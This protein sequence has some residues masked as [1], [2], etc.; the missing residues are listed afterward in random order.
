MVLI[1]PLSPR[2]FGRSGRTVRRYL[3]IE[4]RYRPTPKIGFRRYVSDDLPPLTTPVT[5]FTRRAQ[6][7]WDDVE[8]R[9]MRAAIGAHFAAGR[10]LGVAEGAGDDD[11]EME[12]RVAFSRTWSEC[13]HYAAQIFN[14]EPQTVRDVFLRAEMLTMHYGDGQLDELFEYG[15]PAHQM[16]GALLQAMWKVGGAVHV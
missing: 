15:C 10:A 9:D 6:L 5:Y 11:A 1:R 12:A 3:V 8:F 7:K 4:K 14:S 13:Q 2:P 16:L